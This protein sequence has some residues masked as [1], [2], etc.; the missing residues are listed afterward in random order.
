MEPSSFVS[1]QHACVQL[2]SLPT[3]SPIPRIARI[4]ICHAVKG[5]ESQRQSSR[6][7]S[8]ICHMIVQHTISYQSATSSISPQST[9]SDKAQSMFI[10][11]R[12]NPQ[13]YACPLF[14]LWLSHPYGP[15]RA[16]SRLKITYQMAATQIRTAA[17][18]TPPKVRAVVADLL[19]TEPER[20]NNF[21]DSI[22][23]FLDFC[24]SSH[25]HGGCK[26]HHLPTSYKTMVPPAG[27]HCVSIQ[28][29]MTTTAVAA[30]IAMGLLIIA[31]NS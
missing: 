15:L 31:M 19:R 4:Y 24:V 7:V 1:L 21:S 6:W 16:Y 14:H 9:R 8:E 22:S 25:C 23:Q 29:E 12:S 17:D 18:G 11:D 27:R 2:P 10:N 20:A 5:V 30:L 13:M 26:S 28:L 3:H